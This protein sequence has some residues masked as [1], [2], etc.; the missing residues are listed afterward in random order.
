MKRITV[1]VEEHK[2][3]FF[4]ELIQS[5]D[6]ASIE[7]DTLEE[8]TRGMYDAIISLQQGKEIS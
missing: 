3:P 6:F 8:K 5:L 1:D 4:I 7:E 2:L